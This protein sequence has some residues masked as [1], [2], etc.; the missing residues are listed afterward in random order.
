MIK[1][2]LLFSVTL[3][4]FTNCFGDKKSAVGTDFNNTSFVNKKFTNKVSFSEIEDVCSYVSAQHLAKLYNVNETDITII[5]GNSTNKRCSF[6]VKLSDQKLDH[7]IGSIGFYEEKDK[8]EDGSTWIESWQIRKNVSKSA[9]WIP[10]L[11]QAAYYRGSKREL[12]VKF[13]DYTMSI[14]APGS[15][16]NKIEKE[17][18]RDYKKIALALAEKTPILN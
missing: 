3:V 9:E 13:K 10:N 4:L 12:F 1:K 15:A 14:T 8:N 16:F 17:K 5:K 11:G 7:I 6:Y 18:N 2:I